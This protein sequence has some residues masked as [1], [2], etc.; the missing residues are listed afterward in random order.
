MSEE[1][2]K[3]GGDRKYF[4][5]IRQTRGRF[6]EFEFAIGSPDIA[7]EL[8]M[9][10]EMFDEF[11]DRYGAIGIQSDDSIAIDIERA[12]WRHGTMDVNHDF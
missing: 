12:Q 11:C 9:P 7:V 1:V 8:I 5:R 10:R 4:V 6:V 2:H 3:K